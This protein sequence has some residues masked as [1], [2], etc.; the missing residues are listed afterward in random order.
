[1]MH[2]QPIIEYLELGTILNEEYLTL[3]IKSSS[4][5]VSLFCKFPAFSGLEI[6]NK[7]MIVQRELQFSYAMNSKD[8]KL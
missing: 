3:F 2:S 5:Q 6:K 8:S 1:M 4:P 7:Q